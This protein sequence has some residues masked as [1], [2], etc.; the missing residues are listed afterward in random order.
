MW[1]RPW[2]AAPDCQ[3]RHTRCAWPSSSAPPE[4]RRRCRLVIEILIEHIPPRTNRV[5]FLT[6]HQTSGS[7]RIL[8]IGKSSPANF[9][10]VP[11]IH[12]NERFDASGCIPHTAED[13]SG[14]L[15]DYAPCAEATWR[16][17]RASLSSFLAPGS[18]LRREF[19]S[20]FKLSTSTAR[21]RKARYGQTLAERAGCR[22]PSP[23]P[24]PASACLESRHPRCAWRD[25]VRRGSTARRR[26][27]LVDE[28]RGRAHTQE[29]T[30]RAAAAPPMVHC[31][32]G[33][34]GTHILILPLLL[35]SSSSRARYS[36]CLRTNPN[37]AAPAVSH[38]AAQAQRVE[39]QRPGPQ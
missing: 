10:R 23:N 35:P 25:R 5:A 36:R 3:P 28:G 20:I 4:A 1:T 21:P 29:P 6:S 2:R 8:S 7:S 14:L 13:N 26:C 24:R 17:S 32:S 27:W 31:A 33:R 30:N 19:E 16:H 39:W 18:P 37:T 15:L 9:S 12:I 22:R 38:R 34:V 11:R